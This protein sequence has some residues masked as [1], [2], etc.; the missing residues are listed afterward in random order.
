MN[1]VMFRRVSRVL[2]SPSRRSP[3]ALEELKRELVEREDQMTVLG[4]T[5]ADIEHN[6]ER[7]N[8]QRENITRDMAQVGALEVAGLWRNE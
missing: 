4:N 2:S 5:D 7:L 1:L 3:L 8:T 6:I